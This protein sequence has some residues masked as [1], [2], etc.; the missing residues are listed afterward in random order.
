MPNQENQQPEE[1]NNQIDLSS[2]SNIEFE[3]AW[4]PSSSPKPRS[5][6]GRGFSKSGG[7]SFNKRGDSRRRDF[8]KGEGRGGDSRGTAG[9]GERKFSKG[10]DGEKRFKSGEGR[11]RRFGREGGER[12][13]KN[14]SK[15]DFKKA[16]FKL[17]MEVLFYPD[18]APFSKMADFMKSLK[19]TYQLFEI[20][21]LILEK[22]ERFII[23]LKNLPDSKGEIK[24]L[25]CAQPLNIPFEDEVS[26]KNFAIA[27]YVGEMF[28]EDKIEA[29]PPKGNFQV[30]NRCG[31]SGELLGAPNWHKYNEH[32]RDFHRRKFSKMPFEAFTSKIE[33]LRDEALISEWLEK[34][35]TRAVYRL[36]TPEEGEN[37]VF[38]SL[39][40]ASNYISHK[41]GD[42][43]V[44][45][46]DQV[47]LRG[48]NVQMIP[49]GRIRRNI[50][51]AL[52]MQRKFPIVT[53]NNLRGRLRR[54][55]FSVYK[56]GSKGFAFV[57]AVKRRFLIEGESLS[58]TPQKIFDFVSA[59]AG[60]KKAEVP[61]K[62]LGLEAPVEAPKVETLSEAQKIAASKEKEIEKTESVAPETES[63]AEI[64]SEAPVEAAVE[65]ELQPEEANALPE[66]ELV[67]KVAEETPVVETVLEEKE[68][69]KNKETKIPASENKELNSVWSELSWLISEGYVVEYADTSLQANP[70]MPK[71]KE[72][73]K[74]GAASGEESGDSDEHIDLGE[75]DEPISAPA[76]VSE[77]S[78]EPVEE[79]SE[80]ANEAENA[81]A[82]KVLEEASCDSANTDAEISDSTESVES[83]EVAEKTSEESTDAPEEAS[84]KSES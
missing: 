20:A 43:L 54:T 62:F 70:R 46:Y 82:E 14:F 9:K 50:D 31:I 52:K 71:P 40:A 29:E 41:M 24:P 10:N 34:M 55:G 64:S 42:A 39:E 56:R 4:T 69:A 61:Y 63:V 13:G 48:V 80:A 76:P 30:V 2:L 17:S 5:F 19:R 59:N 26:A 67:E 27:H 33:T 66:T 36:K 22:P 21:Q 58:E 38:E 3:T 65:V 73:S 35:K 57:S 78:S 53:A 25:Y 60:L 45:S 16:P 75:A 1:A 32:L 37:E 84:E 51:E 15:G 79:K 11:E 6:S 81:E 68:P 18:D 28:E 74:K 8:G 12:R 49:H 83:E 23:L 7:G 47:R 72:K 77:T 44:K